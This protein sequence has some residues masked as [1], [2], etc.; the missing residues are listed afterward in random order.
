MQTAEGRGNPK[1]GLMDNS[2][3]NQFA[4]IQKKVRL[5]AGHASIKTTQ[6]YLQLAP[7]DLTSSLESVARI[8]RETGA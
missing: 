3:Q 7:E 4:F 8:L 1:V 6:R 2:I 5:L